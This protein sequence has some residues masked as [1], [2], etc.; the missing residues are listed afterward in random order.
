MRQKLGVG[1]RADDESIVAETNAESLDSEGTSRSSSPETVIYDPEHVAA[2]AAFLRRQS[3]RR[4]SAIFSLPPPPTLGSQQPDDTPY[5][6]PNRAVPRK[7]S[8][9]GPEAA[10]RYRLGEPLPGLPLKFPVTDTYRRDPQP[11]PH[12]PDLQPPPTP[13]FSCGPFEYPPSR[14][15]QSSPPKLKLLRGSP[16]RSPSKN[17]HRDAPRFRIRGNNQHGPNNMSY[18]NFLESPQTGSA[19]Q[20]PR[21]APSPSSQGMPHANG[22]NGVA[23]MPGMMGGLPTPAGHQSD[24]NVIYNMVESLHNELAETR[25]RSERIVAA[26]GIIRARALEQDLTADQIAAGVAAELNEGTKNLEEENSRLRHALEHITHEEAAYKALAE[27]FA[28]TMGNALEMGHAY[29]LKTTLDMCAWHRSYREQLAA[30]R[31]E[32]LELRCRISDMQASAARGM[33]QMR[34]F[35]RGWDRSDL[36]MEMRAE[37]VS[38]RQQARG[39]KRVALSELDSDDSEFSDD[40]DVIDPEEKKRLARVE[41]EKRVKDEME[42][43]RAEESEGDEE[44]AAAAALATALEAS[45]LAEGGGVEVTI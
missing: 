34:L 18:Q 29:K 13:R 23:A 12:T 4:A 39:W 27:E 38:L 2:A 8:E 28:N 36:V 3:G 30:E 21:Q 9:P 44:G 37:I 7:L 6:F 24:L 25:A 43:R 16:E 40:D 32:N 35:R 1:W 19:P 45:Q 5:R 17:Q 15:P 11:Q 22:T 33:E 10:S 41:E 42:A 20:Q 26:A 31:A 14:T